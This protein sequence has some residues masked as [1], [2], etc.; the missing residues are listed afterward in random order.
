[1]RNRIAELPI[2][3]LDPEC[4]GLKVE[5]EDEQG[6][7]VG[8]RIGRYEKSTVDNEPVW[9]LFSEGAPWSVTLKQGTK[10][11]WIPLNV[12]AGQPPSHYPQAPANGQPSVTAHQPVAPAVPA[13]RSPQSW[14]TEQPQ[15]PQRWPQQ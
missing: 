14:V 12:G 3:D 6:I 8:F 9:R 4:I 5:T 11:R 1:M 7:T 15:Q 2:E 13:A 10:L